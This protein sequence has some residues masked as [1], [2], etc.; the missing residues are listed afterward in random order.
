MNILS[1][2]SHPHVIPNLYEFIFFD[3]MLNIKEDILKNAGNQ[4]GVG[5]H[6]LP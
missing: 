5:L 3:P 2:F 6:W 1:L 4:T